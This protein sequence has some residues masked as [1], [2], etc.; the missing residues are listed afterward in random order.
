MSEVR[1]DAQSAETMIPAVQLAKSPYGKNW[2]PQEHYKN[3][4]VA[5]SYDQERFTSLAGRVFNRLEKKLIRKAFAN[6]PKGAV[7]ADI[8]CGTGRLSE[9]LLEQGFT[10]AGMDI[11]PD[12][13]GVAK[14]KLARFGSRFRPEVRDAKTLAGSG[15][16]FDAALCARV[17]MHFPLEEQIVFLKNVAA[18]TAGPVV[19][20]QGVYSPYHRMRRWLKRLLRNQ[21]PAAFS[22]SN[23]DLCRLI[24]AAGLVERQRFRVLPFVSESVVIVTENKPGRSDKGV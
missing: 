4:R 11:S 20:T 1:T 2:Q 18:V 8:P 16:K 10:V 17:L 3:I 5:E 6:V 24:D 15:V 19:F 22:I 7:I 13:L 9:V 21:N 12:M 23:R 14:T